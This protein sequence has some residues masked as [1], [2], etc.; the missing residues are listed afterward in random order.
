VELLKQEYGA[1]EVSRQSFNYQEQRKN[2]KASLIM[3]HR[4]DLL[5]ELMVLEL[6]EGEDMESLKAFWEQTQERERRAMEIADDI[7]PMDFHIYEIRWPE[8]GWMQV[9]VEMVWQM[10]DG[11]CS[12][13]KKTINWYSAE[14]FSM[15]SLLPWCRILTLKFGVG[16]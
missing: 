11:S 3:R 9:G 4:S 16:K 13:D 5:G 15:Q 12:G 1:V 8:N 10:L 14:S 7:F 2:L 6:P